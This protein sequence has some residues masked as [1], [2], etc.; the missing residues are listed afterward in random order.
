MEEAA[1]QDRADLTARL[2]EVRRTYDAFRMRLY[3]AHPEL[4]VQRGEAAPLTESDV[5][6]LLRD[7]E[8]ALLEYVV[9]EQKT[10]LF[11]M[12]LAA[13]DQ[14]DPTAAQCLH[15]CRRSEGVG[16]AC[17]SVPHPPGCGGGGGFPILAQDL[18]DLLLRP[19]QECL[20][21]S[22]PQLNTDQGQP[23]DG[24]RRKKA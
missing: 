12:T 7:R 21:L 23:P 2:D 9:M 5:K 10:C 16:G 14:G 13:E 22:P 19:A 4:R 15:D 8:T 6:E 3:A 17:E 24:Q 20:L 11:V 18:Y 1:P